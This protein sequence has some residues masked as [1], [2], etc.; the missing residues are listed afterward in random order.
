VSEQGYNIVY[1]QFIATCMYDIGCQVCCNWS[2]IKLGF[3]VPP[4]WSTMLQV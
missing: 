1:Q 2:R 3:N 4:Q